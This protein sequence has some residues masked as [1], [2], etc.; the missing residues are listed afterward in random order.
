LPTGAIGAA[1][2]ARLHAALDDAAV[3]HAL[4][5]WTVGLMLAPAASPAPAVSVDRQCYAAGR[6]VIAL[7]GSGYTPG[8][9]VGIALVSE[10]GDRRL[11]ATA[12]PDG[13][14]AIS[15]PAPTL[16]EF[17]AMEPGFTLS[18]TAS[19]R[20]RQGSASPE[21]SVAATAATISEW[22]VDVP[23]WRASGYARPRRPTTLSAYGWTT[24]GGTLYAHYVRGGR[25]L[26]TVAV[27]PLTGACGSLTLRTREFPFRPVPAGTYRV[28][29]DTSRPYRVAGQ[30]VV[31]YRRVK[32]RKKDA[33]R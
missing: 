15:V 2:D 11:S 26:R 21:P 4:L 3:T 18:F 27:G 12:G 6:D 7:S 10:N 17:G 20:A 19:D 33:V 8:G 30:D 16:S 9:E 14:F 29:Y 5:A 23:A 24:L 28:Q 1:T 25:L 32:V 22:T 13:I 31:V